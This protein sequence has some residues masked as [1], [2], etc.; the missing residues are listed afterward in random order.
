[1]TSPLICESPAMLVFIPLAFVLKPKIPQL[2]LPESF[3]I[4][5]QFNS[6][7][8]GRQH[9]M[10]HHQ[11]DLLL[12]LM[13]VFLPR[14][15]L[16]SGGMCTL[17]TCRIEHEFPPTNASTQNSLCRSACFL[18]TGVTT[19][20]CNSFFFAYLVNNPFCCTEADILLIL[21]LE[22]YWSI[23]NDAGVIT[24][25]ESANIHPVINF[26]CS[27]HEIRCCLLECGYTNEI[28]REEGVAVIM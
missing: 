6:S 8:F 13:K 24:H 25:V 11:P 21:M 27:F 1:M 4:Y 9:A 18:V 19:I 20:F 28:H 2:R 12:H 17:S 5:F 22:I 7:T 26:L 16:C 14:P 10:L 23:W 3:G 15:M